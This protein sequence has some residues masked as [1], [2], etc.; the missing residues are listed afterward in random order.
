M[1]LGGYV[2]VTVSRTADSTAAEINYVAAAAQLLVFG[3]L[4]IDIVI[5]YRQVHRTG[6]CKP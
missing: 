4:Y 5:P 3:Q 2:S 6:Q 1:H